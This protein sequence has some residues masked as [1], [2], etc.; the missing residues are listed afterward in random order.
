MIK[1]YSIYY[2]NSE[3][4]QYQ[5]LS[6]KKNLQDNFEYIVINNSQNDP[7]PFP[8]VKTFKVLNARFD[9]AGLSHQHALNW[10]LQTFI[11]DDKDVSVIIDSDI[12][13]VK[14]LSIYTLLTNATY[15]DQHLAGIKQGI[16]N[17]Q[18]LW[19]GLLV[20]NRPKLPVFHTM[21]LRGC[22]IHRSDHKK[23]Y[24][25]DPRNGYHWGMYTKLVEEY[26]PCD[27]G[28]M[29]YQYLIDN[30]QLR[31]KELSV[32]LICREDNTISYIP[33]NLQSLYLTNYVFWIIN[34]TWLH[35]GRGTN[36]DNQPHNWFNNKMQL[37]KDWIK[38][39]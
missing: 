35:F 29:L 16:Q 23:W 5:F 17:I 36:L 28:A 33:K 3:L 22:F 15:L 20:L 8:E 4:L 30:P 12:F 31:I 21:D 37:M 10:A 24:I 2:S 13:L 34:R 19:P 9:D 26:Y 18:Y 1:F 6:L 11:Q 32:E 25:P 27:S 38:S 14:P 7:N 39:L